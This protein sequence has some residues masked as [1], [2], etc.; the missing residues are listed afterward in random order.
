MVIN[1]DLDCVLA[2]E[3]EISQIV[4]DLAYEFNN[5]YAHVDGVN[6]KLLVIGVLKGAVIFMS[7]LIRRIDVPLQIDFIQVSSYGSDTKSSGNLDFKLKLSDEY[8]FKSTD[9]LVVEDIIDS[10]RTLKE[11]T[12]NLLKRGAKS[13]ETCVL[14][15]KP[16]RRVIEYTPDYIG[17]VI[18]DLF[19][20]GYGLDYAE[21][22]RELPYIGVLKPSI[23]T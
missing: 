6:S 19:V 10:G 14:L 21:K 8:D 7:D 15:D 16:L 3:H 11:L 20:V 17:K 9:I 4:K 2:D 1:K 22:Y 23:Y 5:K 18:P 12:I 13:V